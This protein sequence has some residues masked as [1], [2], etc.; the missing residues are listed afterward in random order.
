MEFKDFGELTARVFSKKKKRVVV[1]AAQDAHALEAVLKAEKEGVL[2]Y[3]LVGNGDKIIKVCE[4]LEYKVK[5]GNIIEAADDVEAAFK[6]VELIRL[7][8]GDFLMKGKLSIAEL[9]RAVVD[10]E[11]GI[12]KGGLISH[13]AILEVPRYH[14][15][16]ALTDAGMIIEPDLEQKK[17][18]IKNAVKLF[19]SMGYERPKVAVMAAVETFNEKMK[20]TVDAVKLKEM[21]AGKELDGC[22]L[23][24]PLSFDLAVNKEAVRLKDF[25]SPVAADADILL[26]PNIAAGNLL[27]KGIMYMGDAIMAGCVVGAAAPIVLTSRD[28]S[29]VEKYYSLLLCVATIE[30]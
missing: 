20:E 29:F 26:V 19:C 14:K 18:I 13:V 21:W 23:D 7:K 6:A 15:L 9:L 1:A 12:H 22:I 28:A 5:K 4:F 11:T 2:D 16:L 27:S 3:L 8:K 25:I 30:D 17:E 24:G 10:K